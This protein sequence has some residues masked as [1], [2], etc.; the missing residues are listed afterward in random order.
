[1]Y[2]FRTRQQLL[3]AA[4]ERLA[5]HTLAGLAPLPAPDDAG[6]GD[7]GGSGDL[8]DAVTALLER[9][10]TQGGHL[11]LARYELSLEA[12]RRPEIRAVLVESGAHIRDK[13]A[14]MLAAGQVPDAR[15]RAADL[16]ALLD[17]ILFDRLVGAGG[18]AGT[19]GGAPDRARLRELIGALL[20]A[21]TRGGA[22]P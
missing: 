14:E 11:Q 2:S 7:L 1:S 13:V 6:P 19:D 12:R 8:A 21:V 15:N 22:A 3:Q 10:L 16:V 9:W 4:V 20:L 18:D 17:G 5:E